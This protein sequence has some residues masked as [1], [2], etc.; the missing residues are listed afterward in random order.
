MDYT[1]LI[2]LVFQLQA[3][4]A[5]LQAQQSGILPLSMPEPAPVPSIEVTESD[6][7]AE[8]VE[9]KSKFLTPEE[10]SIVV[11]KASGQ[12]ALEKYSSRVTRDP[13]GNLILSRVLFGIFLNA[14]YQ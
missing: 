1:T 5:V 10:V 3:L 9:K 12:A 6:I 4:I 8:E 13:E 2:A 7:P 14:K 11:Q